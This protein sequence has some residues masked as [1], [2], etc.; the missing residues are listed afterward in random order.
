MLGA[1]F[2]QVIGMVP[3]TKLLTAQEHDGQ[4]KRQFIVSPT[5]TSVLEHGGGVSNPE[6]ES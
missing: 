4:G 6:G 5:R 2:A 3:T 1:V